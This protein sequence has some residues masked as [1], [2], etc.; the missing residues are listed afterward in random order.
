MR[1]MSSAFEPDGMIP[2]KYTCE[3][4]R[5]LS[6]PLSWTEV[7]EGTVSFAL[8]VDDPDAPKELMPDGVFDHW[9]LFNIP[10]DIRDIPEGGTIGTVGVNTRG[11]R[12]YT[13]P[14]PPKEY[15]PSEHRYIFRLYALDAELSLP[16][17]ATKKDVL[18]E[19]SG[20]E[21]EIATLVGRY[22]KIQ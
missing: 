18:D 3:G 9:V 16:E 5:F 22:K 7:P 15:E 20:N 4:D 2:S 14:C 19:L 10:K 21:L 17:G 1:L 11:D 13:G 8:L 6:P 12:K